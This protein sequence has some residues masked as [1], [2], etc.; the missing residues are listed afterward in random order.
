MTPGFENA[1]LAIEINEVDGEAHA[2]G[3]HGFAGN[4]PQA[5]AGREP[6]AA[7]EPLVAAQSAIGD[8]KRISEQCLPREVRDSQTFD[9]GFRAWLPE[10]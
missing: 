6:L 4:D 5:L 1:V 8:F 2:E 7:Q 10:P 3:V 9:R